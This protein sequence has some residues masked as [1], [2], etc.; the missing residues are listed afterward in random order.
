[1]S[2]RQHLLHSQGYETEVLIECIEILINVLIK[3]VVYLSH[4]VLYP[5]CFPYVV[6]MAVTFCNISVV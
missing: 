6:R 5:D 4:L 2:D 3:G 1:M